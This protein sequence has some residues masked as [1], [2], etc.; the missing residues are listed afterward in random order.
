MSQPCIV[1]LDLE[2]IAANLT[3]ERGTSVSAAEALQWLEEEGFQREQDQWFAEAAVI[4]ELRRGEVTDAHPILPGPQAPLDYSDERPAQS[5]YT[6]S[7][8]RRK[9][10]ASMPD[11]DKLLIPEFLCGLPREVRQKSRKIVRKAIKARSWKPALAGQSFFHIDD[12]PGLLMSGQNSA[13][14]DQD[15]V[16]PYI[17]ADELFEVAYDSFERSEAY[18]IDRDLR[19]EGTADFWF[20]LCTVVGSLRWLPVMPQSFD[21]D[22]RRAA[23]LCFPNIMKWWPHIAARDDRFGG[24]LP[25]SGW[26]NWGIPQEFY[27]S[28]FNWPITWEYLRSVDALTAGKRFWELWKADEKQNAK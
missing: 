4:A 22:L 18:S 24:S 11:Y 8:D 7:P 14:T 6:L 27:Y 9:Q 16:L 5:Y 20:S 10:L 23:R 28:L 12:A 3:A 2:R 13:F 26:P 15:N 17:L 19:I 21:D 1:K 25:K